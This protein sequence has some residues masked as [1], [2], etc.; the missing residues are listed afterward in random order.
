MATKAPEELMPQLEP[1]AAILGPGSVKARYGQHVIGSIA[2]GTARPGWE[3]TV[4]G[5]YKGARVKLETQAPTLDDA[6]TSALE[7]LKRALGLN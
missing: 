4:E 3:V 7:E 1:I 6:A 2:L 5:T